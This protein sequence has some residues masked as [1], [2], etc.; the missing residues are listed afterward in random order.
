MHNITESLCC[1]PKANTLLSIN[2]ALH[3]L[4]VLDS[5]QLHG[6]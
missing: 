1:T 3:V 6:R 4:S 5:L 2:H